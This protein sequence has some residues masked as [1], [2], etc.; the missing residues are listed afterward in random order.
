MTP[1]RGKRRA[2]AWIV[3]I[4]V[5]FAAVLGIYRVVFW[6]VI[7]SRAFDGERGRMWWILIIAWLVAGSTAH[8]VTFKW[9]ERRAQ[10]RALPRARVL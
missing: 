7:S 2:I 1:G 10:D 6:G 8:S 5:G 4:V 9:L 3:G